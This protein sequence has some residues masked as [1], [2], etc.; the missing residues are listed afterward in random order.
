[1]KHLSAG[2]LLRKERLQP[3]ED[4]RLI[5]SYLKEGKIVPVEISLNLLRQ[6]M[7]LLNHNRY[8]IDGFPRNFDN[9]L[10]W[11]RMMSAV[12][13]VEMVIYIECEEGELERRLVQR[14]LSSGR[15]DDNIF[16]ARKRFQ[17]FKEATL[18]VIRLFGAGEEEKIFLKAEIEQN[19][20]S[21]DGDKEMGDLSAGKQSNSGDNARNSK[22]VKVDG[23]QPV[24]N[25]F[26]QLKSAVIPNIVK[27]IIDLTQKLNSDKIIDHTVE[28][29][30]K[31]A[32][33]TYG[34][35]SKVCQNLFIFLIIYLFFI[36]LF[37]KAK[38]KTYLERIGC[39]K[40]DS[41][42]FFRLIMFE[43]MIYFDDYFHLLFSSNFQKKLFHMLNIQQFLYL[44]L[45]NLTIEL[46]KNR[47]DS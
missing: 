39:W 46:N 38:E 13:E 1:M 27:E 36:F 4:G 14:G 8:L 25:V 2:E 19:F 44:Q 42:S 21:F 15:D 34:L 45:S 23:D 6:E 35:L 28:V 18:P 17:S 43:E 47:N 33:V 40:R 10:G 3:T 30:G 37:R 5:D 31:S 11:Q 41:G 32:N 24:E 16:T 9:L 22:L 20:N 12:S 26:N 29:Q 7:A